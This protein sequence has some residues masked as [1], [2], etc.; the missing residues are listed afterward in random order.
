[1]LSTSTVKLAGVYRFFKTALVAAIRSAV[2]GSSPGPMSLQ[3]SRRA[4]PTPQL[5]GGSP[6]IV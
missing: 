3:V 4:S 1:M 5:A 2:I 6:S